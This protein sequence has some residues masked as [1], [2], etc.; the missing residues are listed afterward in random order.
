MRGAYASAGGGS[1]PAGWAGL[2]E[3]CLP[4]PGEGWLVLRSGWRV[5]WPA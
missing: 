4:S 5:A 3:G 2:G 1:W